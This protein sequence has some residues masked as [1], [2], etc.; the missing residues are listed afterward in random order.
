MTAAPILM[1]PLRASGIVCSE[2]NEIHPRYIE[3]HVPLTESIHLKTAPPPQFTVCFGPFT[4]LSSLTLEYAILVDVTT[5]IT[6]F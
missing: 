1:Q 5:F 3:L 4:S 6:K 2:T